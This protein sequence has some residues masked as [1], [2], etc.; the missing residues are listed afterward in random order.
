MARLGINLRYSI[1]PTGWMDASSTYMQLD[2]T[3]AGKKT[4]PFATGLALMPD[5]P[6]TVE[7]VRR[8]D[9]AARNRL[10]N[11]KSANT[12]RAYRQRW[13]QFVQWC[14]DMGL[15]PM[16][17][18]ARDL[19]RYLNH[20]AMEGLSLATIRLA[21]SAIAQAHQLQGVTTDL[22]PGK[23]PVVSETI[24]SMQMEAKPQNQARGMLQEDLDAIRATAMIPREKSRGGRP[25]TKEE[26]SRRGRL[27]IA[28]CTLMR[29]AGLRRSEA[30][31]LTWGDLQTWPDGTGRLSIVRSKN[32]RSGSPEVVAV[33]RA[34]MAAL[35]SIRPEPPILGQAIF[36]LSERQI[37]RRIQ[38]AAKHADLGDGFSGH[39][40]RVGL[41]RTMTSNGAPVNA[42]MQQGR[43]RN[44]ETVARYTKGEEAGTALQWLK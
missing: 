17:A 39:S 31:A 9:E 22:N 34:G 13:G 24:R 1:I 7:A 26:A 18:S 3:T 6:A 25:E 23:S 42:T 5:E 2:G 38:D 12:R 27:D 20:L 40:G 14:S 4:E 41:A 11:A 21:R 43:W 19:T 32:N 10:E 29:D 8:L 16:P 36:G 28:L 33:T 35:E 15:S 30:S 37:A 44:S